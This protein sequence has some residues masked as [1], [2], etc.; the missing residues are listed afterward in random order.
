MKITPTTYTVP[1]YCDAMRRKEIVVNRDYQRSNQVWPPAAR[2]FLIETIIL[3]FPIPK[4]CL[5]QYTDIKSRKTYKE[6][7]DGQQRSQTILDFFEDKLRI[8]KTSEITEA[9]GKTYSELEEEHQAAFVSYALSVDLFVS[10]TPDAIREV[11]RRINS[12]T[13][14][15]NAEEQRHSIYQGAF[16]WFIYRL[17]RKYDQNLSDIGVFTERQL[18]RMADAKLFSETSYA[19][20]NGISTTTAKDLNTLYKQYEDGFNKENEIAQR[21][22]KAM[23]FIIGLKDIHN[24]ALMRSHIFYSLLLA[25]SHLQNPIEKLKSVHASQGQ[26]KSQSSLMLSNLTA[27]AEALD[28]E[29]PPQ[30]Y[31]NFVVASTGTT[32]EAS[33]RKSRF[34]W[35]CKALV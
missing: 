35:I 14:P 12:Y 21:I 2:S 11:F 24:T 7:I 34:Q 9:K 16:K 10:A 25:V 29:K 31:K 32:N 20:L 23:N 27:L 26:L 22:N 15:L 6:I 13:V 33:R 18:I 19:I 28:S 30:K 3:G 8:S 1:D 5:S 17:S 4:L